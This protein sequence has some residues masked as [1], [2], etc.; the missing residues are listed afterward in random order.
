MTRTVFLEAL[1]I[2]LLA[3]VAVH[4]ELVGSQGSRFPESHLDSPA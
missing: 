3:E 1:R 2:E 4:Q